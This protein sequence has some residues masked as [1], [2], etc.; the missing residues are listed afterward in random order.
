MRADLCRA[1]RS[2]GQWAPAAARRSCLLAPVRA[3]A[4]TSSSSSSSV[5][6]PPQQVQQLPKQPQQAYVE[7]QAFRI[8]RV[9]FGSILTPIG[10]SFMVYGF[11]A[12]FQMLPGGDISS[13]LLI[14]GF[15]ITVS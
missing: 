6:P 8:E 7:E 2:S 14:Y 11:G 13:L 12:F 1:R 3:E 5:Q 15:P 4:S 10:V 9:S